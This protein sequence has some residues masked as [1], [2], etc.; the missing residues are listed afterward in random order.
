MDTYQNCPPKVR[1]EGASSQ[2]VIMYF[3]C[4]TN[5]CN[6]VSTADM[7]KCERVNPSAAP[8]R[9]HFSIIYLTVLLEN[10]L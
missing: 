10:I 7:W 3:I 6:G 4:E 8:N 5:L 9:F 1:R 2:V